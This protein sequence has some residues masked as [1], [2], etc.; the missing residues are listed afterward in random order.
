VT[1]KKKIG[2]AHEIVGSQM[3]AANAT[4]AT[5]SLKFDPFVLENDDPSLRPMTQNE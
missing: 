2:S 3:M 1:I 5:L 4:I